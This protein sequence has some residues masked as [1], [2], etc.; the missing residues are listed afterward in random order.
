M[1]Q[2]LKLWDNQREKKERERE[3]FPVKGSNLRHSVAHS[4]NKGLSK[5]QR[6]TSRL[7]TGHHHPP[8]EAERQACNTQSWKAGPILAPETGILHQTVSRLL[9][10]YHVFMGSW[11][12]DICQEGHS[13]RSDP[14]RRHIA[15]LRWCSRGTP[16]K[17]SG[18]DL[19]GD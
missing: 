2:Q 15:H 10:A 16:R 4:Q 1:R 12:V 14:Q 18:Q 6:R 9:V 7:H 11:T 13:Q 3:N 8:S 19:G 5:Y 17:H